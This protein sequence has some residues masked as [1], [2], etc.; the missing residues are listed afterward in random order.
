GPSMELAGRLQAVRRRWEERSVL[1]AYGQ[2]SQRVWLAHVLLAVQWYLNPGS[3]SQESGA[4]A[5]ERSCVLSDEVIGFDLP[6]PTMVTEVCASEGIAFLRVDEEWKWQTG[7]R[8]FDADHTTMLRRSLTWMEVVQ[9]G[10]VARSPAA[11]H[12]DGWD[13]RGTRVR[14]QYVL[15]ALRGGGVAR[16]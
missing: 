15:H 6:T 2:P 14:P 11:A 12:R 8:Q 10:C 9:G 5:V 7:R 16:G 1:R 13:E 3:I 4:S